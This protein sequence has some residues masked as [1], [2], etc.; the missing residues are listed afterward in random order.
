LG[1]TKEECTLRI[2][3][4]FFTDSSANFPGRAVID[5]IHL[6][7]VSFIKMDDFKLNTAA[8]D[9]SWRRKANRI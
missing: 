6:I 1:R 9:Y 8:K 3:D 7:K 5:G 4:S 2:T